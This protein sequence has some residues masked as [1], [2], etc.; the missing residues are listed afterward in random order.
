MS[1]SVS[2]E[3]PIHADE[4]PCGRCRAL[5][6]RGFATIPLRPDDYAEDAALVEAGFAERRGGL[7]ALPRVAG[8]CAYLDDATNQCLLHADRPRACREYDCRDPA[9][10]RT[11]LSLLARD[12]DDAIGTP[13][14]E[15]VH[16]RS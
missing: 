5:C 11:L 9:S 2:V 1:E 10:A 12:G 16:W 15:T 6:C 14:W 13:P 4:P 7:W 3:T 8:R